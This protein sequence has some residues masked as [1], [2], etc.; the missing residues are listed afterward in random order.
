MDTTS[1]DRQITARSKEFFASI[2]GEAPSIFNKGWWTGKVMDWSMKNE[3]FK[4][5]LFRF[6]DV[7]PYLNTSESLNRHIKEYFGAED[8]DVPAVMK[9]GAK[10]A[11]FGGKITGAI[12]NRTIRANLE[13]MAQ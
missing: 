3:N 4:I 6:V 7:L 8:Q 5:Q 1:L 11:I 13:G 12:L 10:S 9:W 2:S